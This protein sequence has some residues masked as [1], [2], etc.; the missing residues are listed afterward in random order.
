MDMP[1]FTAELSLYRMRN[2]YFIVRVQGD[3]G[4]GVSPASS[5]CAPC[6]KDLC[7]DVCP[8]EGGCGGDDGCRLEMFRFRIRT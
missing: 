7:C 6:G 8:P 5:C 1:G 3:G 4:A 2:S